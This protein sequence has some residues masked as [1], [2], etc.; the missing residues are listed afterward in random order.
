MLQLAYGSAFH[1]KISDVLNTAGLTPAVCLRANA[2]R[3]QF[4]ITNNSANIVYLSTSAGVGVNEG[5]V[6]QASATYVF[7][8]YFDGDLP[9]L[10]WWVAATAAGSRITIRETISEEAL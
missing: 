3:V 8:W 4:T 7:N 1:S 9:T 2:E 6:L 10:E 5:Y